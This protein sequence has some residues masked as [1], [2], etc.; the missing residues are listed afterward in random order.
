MKHDLANA[1]RDYMAMGLNVTPLHPSILHHGFAPERID[2]VG[3]IVHD[4]SPPT[5][6]I[7]VLT[8][9]PLICV[10]VSSAEGA[11]SWLALSDCTPDR[12]VVKTPIGLLL[13]YA[14]TTPTLTLQLAPG[15][16]VIGG[17][18][19]VPVPPTEGYVWLL[20]PDGEP[21]GEVPAPLERAILRTHA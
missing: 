5:T 8:T 21:V 9:F 17:G 4:F 10:E 18:E 20:P 3:V 6:G 1:A 2:D 16:R 14:A 15:L 7:G 12:W 19:V 13:F 11:V